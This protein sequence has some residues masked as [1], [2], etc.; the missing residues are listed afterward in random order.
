MLAGA[1]SSDVEI[2][3]IDFRSCDFS[4]TGVSGS[5]ASTGYFINNTSTYS[6]SWSSNFNVKLTG[7]RG[8]GLNFPYGGNYN[9]FNLIDVNNCYFIQVLNVGTL[10]LIQH[11]W[12]YGSS[13]VSFQTLTANTYQLLAS[14]IID[15]T[16]LSGCIF[17]CGTSGTTLYVDNQ[18]WIKSGKAIAVGGNGNLTLQVDYGNFAM[19]NISTTGATTGQALLYNS[20]NSTW[21]NGTVSSGSSSLQGCTDVSVT[22]SGLTGTNNFL[23]WNN[24]S[25][26]QKWEAKTITT[27]DLPSTIMTNYT[28][29]TTVNNK[30][31]LV[32]STS[33]TSW[34]NQTPSFVLSINTI[35]PTS[36]ALTLNLGNLN[37][38]SITSATGNQILQYIGG[39]TNK[40]ENTNPTFLNSINTLTGTSNNLTLNLENLND[41]TI[42]SVTNGQ[43]LTY[44]STNSNWVNSSASAGTTLSSLTDVAIPTA[45]NYF[46]VATSNGI[47][48]TATIASPSWSLATP[49]S[50]YSTNAL[51]FIIYANNLYMMCDVNGSGNTF[52]FYTSTNWTNTS[53]MHYATNLYPQ[54][55]FHDGTYFVVYGIQATGNSNQ[56]A[57]STNGVSWSYGTVSSTNTD[58]N[59]M[60][61]NGSVY[62]ACQ[63][64]GNTPNWF[65]TSSLSGTWTAIS[66][67]AVGYGEACNYN[68]NLLW[69]NGSN[70]TLHYS[71]DSL[72]TITTIN[73]G[74]TT[75]TTG[76]QS[77]DYIPF[78]NAYIVSDMSNHGFMT[79]TLQI[80][81][82]A[83][84]AFSFYYSASTIYDPDQFPTFRIASGT[85]YVIRS[86][87]QTGNVEYST[88]GTS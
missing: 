13:G 35:T 45:T 10:G 73:T 46:N 50:S 21:S 69:C 18:T 78:L 83:W 34:T 86:H 81:L 64:G 1:T 56:Y 32:Y 53:T 55:G 74:G 59:A 44:N 6:G 37:Y 4:D 48:Q 14:S 82:N 9:H 72:S 52:N 87:N 66:T 19:P 41:V 57:Y 23:Y 22:E 63:A 76:F 43:V 75:Y 12:F 61:Y 15:T 40:W 54:A 70:G 7:C 39:S 42:S 65:S 17:T 2:E 30:D 58:V 68:S 51:Q 29:A 88:N 33:S 20:S 80:N 11:S 84:T 5:H 28:P 31:M 47:Y 27:G 26:Q 85:N 24:T 8:N 16:C 3:L 77:C 36:G 67:G 71:T 79:S 49:A 25:G 60:V 62:L 38:T